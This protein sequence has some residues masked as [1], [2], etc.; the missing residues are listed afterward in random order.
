MFISAGLEDLAKQG[1]S[2]VP[3]ELGED[4]GDL[5]DVPDFSDEEDDEVA[6]EIGKM[7]CLI[8]LMTQVLS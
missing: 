2:Y 7:C 3:D 4:G 5:D 8:L 1:K 6:A